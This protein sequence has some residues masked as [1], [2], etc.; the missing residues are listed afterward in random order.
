MSNL[1]V[2]RKIRAPRGLDVERDAR[3]TAYLRDVRIAAPFEAPLVARFVAWMRLKARPNDQQRRD[4]FDALHG[5]VRP[6]VVNELVLDES[7][8]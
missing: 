3:L 8:R 5:P 6:F 1:V 2:R 4:D 7:S